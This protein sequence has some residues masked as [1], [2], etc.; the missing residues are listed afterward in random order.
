MQKIIKSY[1]LEDIKE[2]HSYIKKFRLNNLN[3][4]DN[5][6]TQDLQFFNAYYTLIS[7]LLT[8]IPKNQTRS[9]KKI[10]HL[11]ESHCLSYAHQKIRIKDENFKIFPIITFGAKAYH[12]SQ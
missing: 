8:D 9:F 7:N 2:T 10:Y 12:F 4:L 11:G 6:D 1:I 3:P 5:L